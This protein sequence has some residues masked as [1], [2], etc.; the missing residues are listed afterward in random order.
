MYI[1]VQLLGCDCLHL[2][3]LIL[4]LFHWTGVNEVGTSCLNQ[5][6]KVSKLLFE[7]KSDPL[8]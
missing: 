8:A 1:T 6:V 3:P 4:Q 5:L 2:G 7:I